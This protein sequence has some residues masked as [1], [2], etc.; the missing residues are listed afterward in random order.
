MTATTR[1]VDAGGTELEIL[2]AGDGPRRLLLQHG[3]T[4][5]KED[6]ADHVDALALRGWHV[7]APDFRGHGRSDHPEGEDSY[8]FPLFAADLM[9]L[10]D[11]LGWDRYVLLGHSMGGMV[12]QLVALARPERLA[13][14]VL[15][16]TGHGRVEG[17]DLDQLAIVRSIIEEGGVARLVE[18]QRGR[19]GVLDTPAHQRVVRERPGYEEFNESKMLAASSSMFLAMMSALADHEDRLDQL[20]SLTMPT[21]V[22]VG[23]QDAP[24]IADSERMAKAIA[25]ARLVVIPDAGHSPQFENPTAWFEALTGF[26]DSL[27]PAS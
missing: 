14:L 15:M 24:F 8:A 12:A 27:D 18:I 11:A 10:V 2:E 25:G 3:F 1:R 5:A 20:G 26:L 7:V 16:D 17:L 6:F 13:G 23:D 9:A 19:E 22:M 21:L 4:G